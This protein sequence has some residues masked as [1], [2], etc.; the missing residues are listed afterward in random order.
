LD[1]YIK[2]GS[3]AYAVFPEK[4]R[5]TLEAQTGTITEAIEAVEKDVAGKKISACAFIGCCMVSRI[6]TRSWRVL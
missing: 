1:P 4:E 2:D 3:V 5:R 6:I